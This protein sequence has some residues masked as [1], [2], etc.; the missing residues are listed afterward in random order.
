MS[1]RRLVPF[2][3]VALIASATMM[4]PAAT[5]V[6]QELCVSEG[7]GAIDAAVCLSGDE[8]SV[9]ADAGAIDVQADASAQGGG[10]TADAGAADV[11]TGTD[12]QTCADAGAIN[13]PPNQQQC[14]PG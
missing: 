1:M 14:P 8:V 4:F 7:V 13:V 5:A 11:Q 2:A 10:V 12:R 9:V 6:A 3:A